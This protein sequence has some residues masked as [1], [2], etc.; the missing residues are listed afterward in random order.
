ME[1]NEL[2][3]AVADAINSG[4]VSLEDVSKL[5]HKKGD[6]PEDIVTSLH[7]LFCTMSHGSDGCPF[8]NEMVLVDRKTRAG[9]KKWEGLARLYIET[10]NSTVEDLM[11]EVRLLKEVMR[12]GPSKPKRMRLLALYLITSITSSDA[13]FLDFMHTFVEKLNIDYRTD[14]AA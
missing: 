3:K 11:E 1:Y 6:I 13:K 2:V 9:Y 7:I 4:I 5:I 12:E 14:S 8:Y 10:F